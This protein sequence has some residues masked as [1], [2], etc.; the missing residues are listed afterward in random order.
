[1]FI[2]HI[3]DFVRVFV[4]VIWYF[5][6][7]VLHSGQFSRATALQSRKKRISV[8]SLHRSEKLK[9]PQ[10]CVTGSINFLPNKNWL[11]KN[12]S[13]TSQNR[14]FY[15][16]ETQAI[17]IELRPL[18]LIW[19]SILILNTYDDE[20]TKLF[21]VCFIISCKKKL[22][23]CFSPGVYFC[24]T[25]QSSAFHRTT[26]FLYFL[27][28]FAPIWRT[29]DENESHLCMIFYKPSFYICMYA[30]I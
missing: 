6:C 15:F 2:F 27:F 11:A 9:L 25:G 4:F 30:H 23:W 5:L 13:F 14:L 26:K 12:C 22:Y 19:F 28:K 18:F 1:M 21:F 10:I 17:S 3:L 16:Q 29:W 24:R 20:R 8:D 7:D